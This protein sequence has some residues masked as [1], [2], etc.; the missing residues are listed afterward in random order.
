MGSSWT[1]N[2]THVPSIGR[3]ILIHPTTREVL[4]HFKLQDHYHNSKV[5]M[6]ISISR[7]L[8]K[9]M[10][11]HSSSLA[12]RIPW[13]EKPGRLQSMGSQRVGHNW[14]NLA[15]THAPTMTGRYLWFLPVKK[16]WDLLYDTGSCTQCSV[17]TERDGTGWEVGGR[18]KR[19]GT[20]VSLWL[21]PIDVRQKPTQ[22]CKAIILQLK[23][24]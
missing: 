8:A 22:H 5:L 17:T 6:S 7:S 19:E 18:F 15:C 12:W 23:R 11:T 24:N 14:S 16:S 9:E 10:A 2:Q 4:K 21:I 1:K 3:Q 13:T 20:H